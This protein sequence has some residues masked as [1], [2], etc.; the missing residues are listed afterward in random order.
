MSQTQ[1]SSSV[2]SSQFSRFNWWVTV[3][4]HIPIFIDLYWEGHWP[5]PILSLKLI[6]T[7]IEICRI[8]K[9]G[10]GS[11]KITAERNDSVCEWALIWRPKQFSAIWWCDLINWR[12]FF[13][14]VFDPVLTYVTFF[15]PRKLAGFYSE[16]YH[17]DCHMDSIIF[18]EPSM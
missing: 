17:S 8:S 15:N 11:I 5:M 12:G 4:L 2:T 14:S 9:F 18:W 1:P 16:I 3:C 6:L 7:S 13:D 10:I